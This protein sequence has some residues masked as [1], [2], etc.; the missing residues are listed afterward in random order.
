M[1]QGG[2]FSRPGEGI[3]IGCAHRP[4]NGDR[5]DLFCPGSSEAA[6][7]N[8]DSDLNQLRGAGCIT[9][10]SLFNESIG[11]I[12]ASVINLTIAGVALLSLQQ[13]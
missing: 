10:A 2:K 5:F 12:K 6:C 7:G 11:L 13:K 3:A 9:F 4:V 8:G 1:D